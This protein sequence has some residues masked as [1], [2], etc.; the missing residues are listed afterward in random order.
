MNQ[1]CPTAR[2]RGHPGHGYGRGQPRTRCWRPAGP[3]QR[4]RQC[5]RTAL[6]ARPSRL[7]Q[8]LTFDRLHKLPGL[9]LRKLD[10]LSMA[11]GIEGHVPYCQPAVT[12]FARRTPDPLKAAAGRRKRILWDAGRPLVPESVRT[13]QKQPFTFPVDSFLAPGTG[14]W[15]FATDVLARPRLCADGF[16]SGAAVREVLDRHAARRDRRAW[17]GA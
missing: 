9:N 13:R 1:S 8:L 6:P 3:R 15:R 10:H 14:L 11:H 4:P 12:E 16:L 7:E 5:P 2:G 17:C